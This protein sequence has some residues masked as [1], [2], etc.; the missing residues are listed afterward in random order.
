MFDL[1]RNTPLQQANTHGILIK[2]LQISARSTNAPLVLTRVLLMLWIV[3]KEQWWSLMGV[4]LRWQFLEEE[5]CEGK[6]RWLLVVTVELVRLMVW[7]IS[8][9]WF[10]CWSNL[11]PSNKHLPVQSQQKKLGEGCKICSKL[12]TSSTSVWCPFCWLWTYFTPFSSVSIADYEQVNVCWEKLVMSARIT[13][14]TEKHLSVQETRSQCE[15]DTFSARVING[16][17]IVRINN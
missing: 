1:V 7:I 9:F 16:L 2:L 17:D 10:V 15:K 5:T 13:F 11:F 3:K 14:S 6:L 4:V 8:L 12:S